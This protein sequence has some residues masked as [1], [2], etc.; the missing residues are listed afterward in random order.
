MN[1]RSITAFAA[2][3]LTV[4]LTFSQERTPD[5]VVIVPNRDRDMA[6]AIANAQSTLDEFLTTWKALPAGTSGY[7]LKVR[8]QDDGRSE[9]FWVSPFREDGERFVG[10][11][12]NSPRVVKNV[13][14]GQAI[15]FARID[16]S[17]WGYVKDGKQIGSYTVCVLF[18]T[19]PKTQADAYR[20]DYGFTC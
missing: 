4:T 11:L 1:N 10:I 12:A 19:M 9:H 3:F 8:I 16:V 2:I 5:Q 13:K 6:E 18:K 15:R 14:E 17:D 7:K 20:K